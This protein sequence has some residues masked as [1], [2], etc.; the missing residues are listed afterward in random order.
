MTKLTR[1]FLAAMLL[2]GTAMVATAQVDVRVDVPFDFNLN[3]KT[4]P[5]GTYT[6]ARAFDGN[7]G[8]LVLS[9][10]GAQPIA[11]NVGKASSRM[12]GASLSF[13]QL[14]E[15]YFLSGVTTATGKYSLPR[16]RAERLAARNYAA[17]KD[18]VVVG[19]SK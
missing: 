17:S 18:E 6:V 13:H 8:V 4:L 11:F 14:G 9:G 5:A 12:T 1:V 2:L 10:A 19:S 3:G 16:T 7:P 15:T